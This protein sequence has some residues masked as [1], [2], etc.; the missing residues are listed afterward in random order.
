MLTIAE[1]LTD[2]IELDIECVD[3]VYLNGYIKYLQMPGG[4]V[5]F[6]RE[7]IGWPIPSPKALYE[8]TAQFRAAV[9]R[10]ATEQ[11]LKIITFGKDEAKDEVAQ[12]HLARFE[13]QSG[14]VLIGKAQEKA[15][16]Y[17]GRRADQG[18]KVWFNYSRESVYVTHY[19]FY[20][21][22]ED[23]GLFFIKMC[24]YFPF[25]VKVCFNGHEWAKQQLRQAGIAF[26]ALSNGFLACDDPTRLQAICHQLNADKIQVLF[27]R[28]V[29]QLPWPLSAEQR[30]AGY[31]H[32]LSIWQLEVSRTQVFADPE[33]G[34]ALVESLIRDNL[35]LGRPD[36]VSLI[37]ERQ[38]TKRTPSQFQTRVIREGVL[39]SIRISYKH[40]ALKQYLKDGRALRTE[41][42]IN[43]TQDFGSNRGL[44][45]FSP[46]VELGRQFNR[47]LLEQERISQDCFVPLG[48]LRRLGQST[49]AENGQRASALRFGDQRV[50][51][52]LAALA[53][54]VHVPGEVSNKTLRQSVAQLLGV[55]PETYASAKM[56]YDLRRLRLKGLI[57]RVP[58][59]QRYVLTPLGAKVVAFF[60]KLYERLFRP[61]LAALV[62]DQPWPSDLAQALNRLDDVIQSWIHEA[63]FPSVAMAA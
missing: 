2:K 46:L 25:D 61:G 40:S 48:E 24:T 20:I 35:D 55:S 37:F 5:N 39:P 29:E 41:M 53:R 47:R 13:G 7:Q 60:T 22:D 21:L 59:S 49:L 50:M 54:F 45:N 27:D 9:E 34:W 52:L 44:T 57:E 17:K 43:N 28:W 36:R 23:F 42:M 30:A 16:A 51:A 8:M 38:V 15:N 1:V 62:P 56:S 19:Y 4:L 3:R 31:K 18:N 11:G 14:V 12:A 26:E 63:L 58:C 33:Q 10:F 6:I 32:R